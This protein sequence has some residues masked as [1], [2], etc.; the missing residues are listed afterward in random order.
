M[1]LFVFFEEIYI[2][3]FRL[4]LITCVFFSLLTALIIF[5]IGVFQYSGA[6]IKKPIAISNQTFNDNSKPL[7]SLNNSNS[8]KGFVNDLGQTE[9]E[10]LDAERLKNEEEA[11]KKEEENLRKQAIE[12]Q[13]KKRT[14][15][16]TAKNNEFTQQAEKLTDIAMKFVSMDTSNMVNKFELQN[17]IFERLRD[18]ERR[19]IVACFLFDADNAAS[20]DATCQNPLYESRTT[21]NGKI[22]LLDAIDFTKESKNLFGQKV[23][24]FEQQ[25]DTLSTVL[26][27][28]KVID[29]RVEKKLDSSFILK[30]LELNHNYI[31]STVQNYY[32]QLIFYNSAIKEV[33]KKPKVD[34]SG[35]EAEK[36]FE[37]AKGI[38]K[39]FF[40]LIA[41]G[42]F[43][44]VM[45]L[46]VFYKIERHLKNITNA[47]Q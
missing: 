24:Y 29:L 13:E 34:L 26:N 17:A 44:A 39:L 33:S 38:K 5:I 21:K 42:I 3:F 46:I 6:N 23:D 4:I 40:S 32:E 20:T 7:F 28:Q 12:E 22:L 1:K 43:I 45:L 19:T 30:V 14:L 18:T 36:N 25:I 11:R 9:S 41:F 35:Y 37:K 47:K 27:N 15:Y 16:E 2:K 31:Q 8:I 10:K